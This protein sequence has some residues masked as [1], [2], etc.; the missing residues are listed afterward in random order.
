MSKYATLTE[1][2]RAAITFLHLSVGSPVRGEDWDEY[3]LAARL[4]LIDTDAVYAR[5]ERE[6]DRAKEQY[7]DGELDL[8]EFDEL[9]EYIF[10]QTEEAL[11]R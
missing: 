7:I 10:S 3:A 4:D 11:G 5:R 6:L 1:A 9:V 8:F 2:H